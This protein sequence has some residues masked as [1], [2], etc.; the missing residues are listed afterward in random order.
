MHAE[1]T[2]DLRSM[3]DPDEFGTA[4]DYFDGTNTTAVNVIFQRPQVDVSLGLAGVT[5]DKDQ[6]RVIL[7]DLPKP[8]KE[9]DTLT[10]RAVPENDPAEHGL[11]FVV[12]D[13][14][15]ADTVRHTSLLNLR[16]AGP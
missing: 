7:A 3:M 8:P 2:E 1:D 16:P 6:A 9:A 4:V 10:I 12:R 14:P 5:T 15:K 11:A 13:P